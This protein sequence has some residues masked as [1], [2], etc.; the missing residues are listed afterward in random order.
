MNPQWMKDFNGGFLILMVL[1]AVMM[2]FATL[3]LVYYHH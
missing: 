3:A 1:G 2:T